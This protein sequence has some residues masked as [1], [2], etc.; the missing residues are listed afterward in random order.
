MK[1]IGIST[2]AVVSLALVAAS[3]PAPAANRLQYAQA[4]STSAQSIEKLD[5]S[6]VPELDRAKIRRVQMALRAKGFDPGSIN[7]VVGAKTKAAVEKYQDRFGIK[8]TGAINNQTLFA[9]GIVGDTGP[10]VKQEPESKRPP[11]KPSRAA[12][13][14]SRARSIERNIETGSRGRTRWCAAYYNGSQN[15]GFYTLDQCRAAVSGVG[16]SCV[17]D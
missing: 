9:L 8:A 11:S 7:G 10:S 15:C 16:G 14:P 4:T 5:M 13:S 6:A 3:T 17:P 12:K 1:T 2:I